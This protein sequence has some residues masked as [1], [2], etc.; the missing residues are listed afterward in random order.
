MLPKYKCCYMSAKCVNRQLFANMLGMTFEAV[1]SC[2]N[3]KKKEKVIEQL[4][5]SPFFFH[6]G[7]LHLLQTLHSGA[8]CRDI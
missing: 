5:F 3:L 8:G 6:R 1:I 4:F 7:K 2:V